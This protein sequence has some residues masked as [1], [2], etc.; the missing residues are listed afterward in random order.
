MKNYLK[1]LRRQPWR[2][3]LAHLIVD[4]TIAIVIAAISSVAM[5]L[6]YLFGCFLWAAYSSCPVAFHWLFGILGVIGTWMWT[7]NWAE[8]Q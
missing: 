7:F 5:F 1:N 3:S 4:G 6:M 2:K 8:R